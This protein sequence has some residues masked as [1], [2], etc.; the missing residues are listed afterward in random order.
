[1]KT[2]QSLRCSSCCGLPRLRWRLMTRPFWFFSDNETRNQRESTVLGTF[3]SPGDS[4]RFPMSPSGRPGSRH[5][6]H[7]RLRPKGQPRASGAGIRAGLQVVG[8]RIMK[9]GP[10]PQAGPILGKAGVG[11]GFEV[12]SSSRNVLLPRHLVSRHEFRFAT[13]ESPNRFALLAS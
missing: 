13:R 12:S 1:M 2:R 7:V 4:P 9:R 8:S 11:L 10:L 5:G 6:Q 3:S